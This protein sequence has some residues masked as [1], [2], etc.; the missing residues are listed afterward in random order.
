MA[1]P[2]TGTRQEPVTRDRLAKR[3]H[4][5]LQM[6]LDRR[7]VAFGYYALVNHFPRERVAVIRNFLQTEL[8]AALRDYLRQQISQDPDFAESIKDYIDC[9]VDP[10]DPELQEDGRNFFLE[11][12]WKESRS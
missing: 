12:G 7:M 6:N 3:D 8:E 2:H 10:E 1:K 11:L 5:R 9:L 4:Y